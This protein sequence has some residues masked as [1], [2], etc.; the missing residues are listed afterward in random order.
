MVYSF[1]QR[2]KEHL[3]LQFIRDIVHQHVFEIQGFL[4]DR[5]GMKRCSL[6]SN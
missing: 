6:K 4:G 3:V 2:I 5:R 1:S